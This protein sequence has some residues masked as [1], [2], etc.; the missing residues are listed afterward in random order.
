MRS[1]ATWR[2][3]SGSIRTILNRR[4][5]M[6]SCHLP[7]QVLQGNSDLTIA[8]AGNPNVGKSSL[9]NYLTGSS[10]D[11]ANY[12]GKTVALN[13]GTTRFDGKRIGIIDLPGTYALGAL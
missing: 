7:S 2:R 10:V 11:T 9:F 5:R 13:Y 6:S 12:P 1:G 4:I 8:L 3:A